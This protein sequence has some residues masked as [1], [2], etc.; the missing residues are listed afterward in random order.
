MWMFPPFLLS[1]SLL[2]WREGGIAETGSAERQ[3]GQ[4]LAVKVRIL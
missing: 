3:F 4:S 1:L 2:R